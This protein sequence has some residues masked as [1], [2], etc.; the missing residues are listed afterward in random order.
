M[1]GNGNRYSVG[2]PPSVPVL[3]PVTIY[4]SQPCVAAPIGIP[5][6]LPIPDPIVVPIKPI[7]PPLPPYL[8]DC[9]FTTYSQFACGPSNFASFPTPG[10][11]VGKCPG[12]TLT[13]RGSA[14][15]GECHAV[16]FPVI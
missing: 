6:F 9:L 1:T 15:L 4:P 13:P 5:P 12:T 14:Y 16:P 8:W 3:P 10:P 2:V 7:T 11:S